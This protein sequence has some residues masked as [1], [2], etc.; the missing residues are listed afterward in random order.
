VYLAVQTLSPHDDV[1]RGLKTQVTAL[2]LDVAELRTLLL[3]QSVPSISVPLLVTV[4]CWLVMIFASFA[5]LAPSNPTTVVSLLAAALSVVGAIFLILELDQPLDGV[6]RIS[7]A[8]M[9]A[10]TS[11][12]AR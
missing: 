2:L 8:P 7:S 12:M 10:V 6:I 9:V 3:A 11:H 1:E 5:L 4:V